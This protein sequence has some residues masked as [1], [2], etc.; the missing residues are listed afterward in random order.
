MDL[1]VFLKIE[2]RHFLKMFLKWFP[3]LISID[4][5]L[6]IVDKTYWNLN[7]IPNNGIKEN[8]ISDL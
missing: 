5:S 2:K 1:E 8:N 4:Y 6:K 3:S 7:Y